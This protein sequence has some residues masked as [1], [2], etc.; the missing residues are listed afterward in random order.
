VFLTHP[1]SLLII[2]ALGGLLAWRAQYPLPTAVDAAVA[3]CVAAGW[4]LQVRADV[5]LA[6]TAN[7]CRWLTC[8]ASILHLKTISFG[9][10]SQL[11]PIHS[12]PTSPLTALT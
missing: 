9:R 7:A 3:A 11:V 10:S 4:C 12:T 5:H 8:M 6:S 1:S 2:G